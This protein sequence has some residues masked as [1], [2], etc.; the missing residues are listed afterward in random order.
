LPSIAACSGEAREAPRGSAGV[1]FA[2]GGDA[3]AGVAGVGGSVSGAGGRGAGGALN[4]AGTTEAGTSSFGGQAGTT[5]GNGAGTANGGGGGVAGGGAGAG[6]VSGMSGNAGRG[7][8]AGA[9][10]LGNG[11]YCSPCVESADCAFGAYCVGGLNPRCGKTC[12]GDSDCSLGTATSTC[13]S[14]SIGGGATPGGGAASPPL[15]G[16]FQPASGVA[17]L[18]CTPSDAVCGTGKTSALLTCN[19]SWENYAS[20]F[21]SSTCIGSCHRHDTMFTTLAAVQGLADAIRLE[22]D[23]GAMPL[24]QTLPDAQ[25][26]RLLTWLAC[27]AP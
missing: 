2:T 22:V 23:S 14:V 5:I 3:A 7:G 24:D 6:G 15:G 4:Q 21:F 1:G 11:L 10:A 12:T 13:A 20:G 18:S 27:G 17:L 8:N 16:A 19:D 25:R 9:T 26:R